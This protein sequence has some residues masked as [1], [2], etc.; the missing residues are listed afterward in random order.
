MLIPSAKELSAC[1][2]CVA[3]TTKT[4]VH[5]R[6]RF[7]DALV[8]IRKRSDRGFLRRMPLQG[9]RRFSLGFERAVSPD[10]L[11]GLTF[12]KAWWLGSEVKP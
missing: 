5:R 11:P 7:S 8:R 10:H 9:R 6:G 2:V 1:L 4:R 12:A 3:Q